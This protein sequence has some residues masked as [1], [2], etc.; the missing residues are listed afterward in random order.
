MNK[1]IMV[2]ISLAVMLS[3]CASE[4]AAAPV[5]TQE[6]TAVSSETVTEKEASAA[7]TKASETTTQETVTEE[8]TAVE[9]T[10]AEEKCSC[11]YEWQHAFAE[12]INQDEYYMKGHYNGIYVGDING[13]DI[14]EAVVDCNGLGNTEI[15]FYTENGVKP[16]WIGIESVWGYVRYLPETRQIMHCPFYGHTWG[17]F[18][19]EE[20]YIYDITDSDISESFSMLR[21][22]GYYNSEED[23]GYD[24]GYINGEEVDFE[25]FEAKLAEIKQRVNEAEYF[26]VVLKEDES[27]D[28]YIAENLPCM[29]I[30]VEKG[31]S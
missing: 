12:Y 15:L 19:Y 31:Q 27:F 2:L 4:N 16:V 14:P 17:T 5:T 26:P 18:G 7:E 9:T 30:T 25:T 6:S 22:S 24:K 8:T 23:Y 29:I 10:A 28:S 20:H 21:K 3:A 13:D 1:K 11:Q